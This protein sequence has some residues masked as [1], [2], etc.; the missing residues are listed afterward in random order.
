MWPSEVPQPAEYV[1]TEEMLPLQAESTVPQ[2]DRTFPI[3]QPK[4]VF[5]KK[6][7]SKAKKLTIVAAVFAAAGITLFTGMATPAVILNM[8][9]TEQIMS[10]TET[11][12]TEETAEVPQT[13]ET[14]ATP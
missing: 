14:D 11:A 3:E 8:Q 13:G 5:S 7:R 1:K 12:E 6:D 10:A 2:E 4:S 9:S